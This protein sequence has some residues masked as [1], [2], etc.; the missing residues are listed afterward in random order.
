[1]KSKKAQ[2]KNHLKARTGIE[3]FDEITNGGLPRGRT[4]LI[5]GGPGSGKTIMGLQS[6]VNGACLENEPGIFV[7]FEES[8]ER[9]IANAEKFGWD[10]AELQRK[11]LFFLNAQP[12][13]DLFQSGGFDLSGMLA[14]LEAKAREIKA[15]RIVFDAVDV[16]LALLQDPIAARR[17]IYRLHEWLLARGFT[18]LITSKA[19]AYE[20]SE[21]NRP[22]LGFMQFMVDC[23]VTLN[24]EVV[25]GISQ[26]NLRVVK[27]RGSAFSE[28]ESPFLIGLHGLEVA[29]SR[30]L[31]R[32]Q[33]PETPVLTE[34]ISTGVARLDVMLGGGY[35]RGAGVL[36]TGFPGTCKSTLSGAFTEAA[37]L[38]GERTLF[39]SFDSDANEV[40][41][42]LASVNIR[43]ERFM[44]KGLLRMV[45]ARAITGSAEIH[46]MQ[47]KNLAKEHGA[48]CVVIDPV[49]ALSKSGNEITA[50]SVAERLIDWTKASG[51]TLVCTS[52]LHEAGLQVEGSA[53]QISTIADTWIH[54][55]Y[56]VHAGERNR[57]L[58]IIKSR[59]T[60]HSNQ[61][62]ELVLSDAG[63]TLADAYTAGG[64][65]LM[66][67]LRWEKERA[68]V[69]ARETAQ[70]AA[71]QKQATIETEEALL[72]VR[73]K[74][75]QLELQEKRLEKQ[76]LSRTATDLTVELASG[77]THMSE[78][79]GVDKK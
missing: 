79:R 56:L 38:R 9:I 1:M 45:S 61:V 23:S 12:S 22:Q 76:A 13:V 21:V 78:L 20:G 5:E 39:I 19:G 11:K 58:S 57:G 8:S 34:R 18:S 24:H 29:G 63:V 3:G 75:V 15:K 52:L 7:A 4:T 27:Y 48:R 51:I 6:L 60:S 30:E 44:K 54:L 36:I 35:Y 66:G 71:K 68:V 14:A 16:V 50:S 73:L 47:I 74:A 49:S 46:L 26:R 64:E 72:E 32:S 53:L 33:K 40:V 43:L 42:N 55:N 70:I 41:R 67:T 25:E 65:V 31:G 10:L 37:C 62:R 2:V 59:G 28:N 17:E 77:R 69:A